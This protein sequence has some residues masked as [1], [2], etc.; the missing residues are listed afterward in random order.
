MRKIAALVLAVI[1]AIAAA[2]KY[3]MVFGTAD[4]WGNYSITSVW[5]LSM[6]NIHRILA[7]CTPI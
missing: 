3:A 4:Y 6:P 2:E 7:V 5:A 1:V